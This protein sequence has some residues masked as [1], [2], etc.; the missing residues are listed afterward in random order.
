VEGA[1]GQ[2]QQLAENME[3]SEDLQVCI[4]ES[5]KSSGGSFL[6]IDFGGRDGRNNSKW[7]N[8]SGLLE[9]ISHTA[10]KMATEISNQQTRI[11]AAAPSTLPK[12]MSSGQS[13][14]I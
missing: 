3:K 4:D 5:S 9:G 8:P 11:S 14:L 6:E 2:E 13:L 10:E 7:C 12:F 1:L